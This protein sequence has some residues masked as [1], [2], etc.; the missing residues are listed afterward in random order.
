M[1]ETPVLRKL[2]NLRFECVRCGVVIEHESD[3]ELVRNVAASHCNVAH[4]RETE[5]MGDMTI[6]WSGFADDGVQE[7]V[8]Q[9]VFSKPTLTDAWV[10]ESG[11]LY[12]SEGYDGEDPTEELLRRVAAIV[13]PDLTVIDRRRL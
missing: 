5:W 9:A 6:A 3:P 1:E 12:E 2:A 7:E 10:L 13:G 11:V 4:R 8:S